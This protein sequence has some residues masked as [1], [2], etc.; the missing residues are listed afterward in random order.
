MDTPPPYIRQ[1]WPKTRQSAR[2][3][4]EGRL[5]I[6]APDG[7]VR[8]WLHDV[9]EDGVGGVVSV[10]LEADAEV[11][12]E[13]ELSTEKEPLRTRAIVRY[14]SGFRYG[15]RFLSLTPVQREAI[16]RYCATTAASNP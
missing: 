10:Q 9:S 1:P 7:K 16:R 15:F 8:G 3:P 5:T 13:F 14:S 2:Q 12:I 4:L 6:Q 11:D